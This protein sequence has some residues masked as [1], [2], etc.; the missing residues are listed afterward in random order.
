MTKGPDRNLP[1]SFLDRRD[2]D[3]III[4]IGLSNYCDFSFF[5]AHVSHF[6]WVKLAN[7]ENPNFTAVVRKLGIAQQNSFFA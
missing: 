2:F 7:K 3:R 1:K 6:C 5:Q 4:T